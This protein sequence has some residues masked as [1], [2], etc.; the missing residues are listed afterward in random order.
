[1]KIILEGKEADRYLLAVKLYDLHIAFER[2]DKLNI[3]TMWCKGE[4]LIDYYNM[5]TG[6]LQAYLEECAYLKEK[7]RKEHPHA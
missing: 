2:F 5:L 4:S 1:M 7:E 3:D 6:C